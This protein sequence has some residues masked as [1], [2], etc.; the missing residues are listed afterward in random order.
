MFSTYL[1]IPL[2][3][4]W[5]LIFAKSHCRM[6]RIIRF[7]MLVIWSS[8]WL[9]CYLTTFINRES[10]SFCESLITNEDMFLSSKPCAGL[11]YSHYIHAVTFLDHGCS[12][13]CNY[14][15]CK[16]ESSLPQ[17]PTIEAYHCLISLYTQTTDFALLVW[18]WLG[19]HN[20]NGGCINYDTH[21]KLEIHQLLEWPNSCCPSLL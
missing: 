18:L 6:S 8:F 14:L 16:I 15:C 17:V 10:G 19:Q 20:R 5:D 4:A 2:R 1:Y 21:P 11:M 3:Y 13:I 9:L 7:G 12:H